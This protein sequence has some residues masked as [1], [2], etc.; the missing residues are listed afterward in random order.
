MYGKPLVYFDNGATTQKPRLVVDAL[1]DEYY[2]VNANVHREYITFSQQ[3]TELHEASRETVRQ[4][5]NANG[6][7]EVVFTRGTTEVSICLFPVLEMSLC[8]KAMK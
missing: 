4:F 5:I 1:V 3:A 8:R 6:T 7:N 2:S